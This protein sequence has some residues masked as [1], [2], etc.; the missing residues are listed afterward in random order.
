M[1]IGS[2]GISIVIYHKDIYQS[3]KAKASWFM[4]MYNISEVVYIKNNYSNHSGAATGTFQVNTMA[5]TF[6]IS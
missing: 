5:N 1:E 6:Y 4:Y 3:P 2:I